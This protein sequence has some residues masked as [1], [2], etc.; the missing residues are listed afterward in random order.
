MLVL[1]PP[2]EGKTAPA[3]GAPVDLAALTHPALTPQRSKVIAVLGRVARG[4]RKGALRTLGLSVGQADEIALDV[5]LLAAPAAPA[6]EVYT[7]VLYQHLDLASL[8]PAARSRAADR[9]LVASALWGVVGLDDRI[10]AYRLSM[11]ARLPRL[12]PLASWWRP[13]LTA[14]L[15]AD[16]LVVDLRSQPYAAAWRPAQGTVV[17]V[18]VFVEREGRRTVVSHMAKATRGDVARLLAQARGVPGDPAAIAAVVQRAGHRVELARE[19]DRGA[20]ATW[21]LDVIL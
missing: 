16:A 9:M 5:D 20:T 2:S 14:A 8:T 6:A 17:A 3:S 18:R 4:S 7:G 12:A 13:A 21:S 15:P 19:A 11:G 1:L 10:P